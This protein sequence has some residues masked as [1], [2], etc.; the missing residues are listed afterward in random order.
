MAPVSIEADG[1]SEL[2]HAAVSR[3]TTTPRQAERTPPP[4]H[5]KTSWKQRNMCGT[6]KPRVPRL[7]PVAVREETGV[8]RE[9]STQ[10]QRPHPRSHAAENDHSTNDHSTS[11]HPAND[12]S[13]RDNREI[14]LRRRPS[15]DA[16]GRSGSTMRRPV[17]A[18]L[19]GN[20]LSGIW[21]PA[22]KAN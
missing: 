22:W 6:A 13:T 17:C 2:C 1:K 4:T 16:P 15:V 14:L 8:P 18:V 19:K 5:T 11:D 20:R 7:E 21:S 12:R 10:A 3:T 9:T